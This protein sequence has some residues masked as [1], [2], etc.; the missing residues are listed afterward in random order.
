M[1]LDPKILDYPKQYSRFPLLLL[2]V[3]ILYQS[4]QGRNVCSRVLPCEKSLGGIHRRAE[5]DKFVHFI[6]LIGF[7]PD[8]FVKSC[9][10]F[11]NR[12]GQLTLKFH[13][14]KKAI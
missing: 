1:P 5:F 10:I 3:C 9:P 6:K 4:L 14:N 7:E 12:N 8:F 2:L 13:I 11:Q